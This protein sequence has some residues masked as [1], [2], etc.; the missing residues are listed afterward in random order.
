M[1]T[2]ITELKL[3]L[4]QWELNFLKMNGRK[5]TKNDAAE[6]PEIRDKYAKFVNLKKDFQE[7]HRTKHNVESKENNEN[8]EKPLKPVQNDSSRKIL[9]P[10]NSQVENSSV[11]FKSPSKSS[12]TSSVWGENLLKKNFVASK[13][14]DFHDSSPT[15]EINDKATNASPEK[16]GNNW[17]DK[18]R[19]NIGLGSAKHLATN[20]KRRSRIT[21]ALNSTLGLD[22]SVV[23]TDETASDGITSDISFGSQLKIVSKSGNS[24]FNSPNTSFRNSSPFVPKPPK[25][26]LSKS[27]NMD[28]LQDEDLSD[29]KNLVQETKADSNKDTEF[30][31]ASETNFSHENEVSGT[32]E[33]FDNAN[34]ENV[35]PIKDET[36]SF[37]E[38]NFR[39]KPKK[40]NFSFSSD[41]HFPTINY[42]S[43]RLNAEKMI[44]EVKLTEKETSVSDDAELPATDKEN[45]TKGST[46]VKSQ[47][48]TRAIPQTNFVLLNMKKKCYSKRGGAGN[49]LRKQVLRQKLA[50]KGYS[51]KSGWKGR[52][53]GSSFRSGGSKWKGGGDVGY[54][55]R[56]A[57]KCFK[58][59]ETGHWASKCRGFKS[60]QKKIDPEEEQQNK[61]SLEEIIENI[62][63]L[64]SA[65]KGESNNEMLQKATVGL[66]DPVLYNDEPITDNNEVMEALLKM[67][68]Y[69]SFRPGQDVAISRI[70]RGLPTLLVLSTGSGKSLCYQLPAYLYAKQRNAI[71]LVISPLVSLMDDQVRGLPKMMKA[72]RIHSGMSKEQ[73]NKAMLEVENGNV[74]VLLVSPEAI[75]TWAGMSPKYSPLSKLPP[76]AFACV[77][78]CHCL[79]EW[80]H[81]FRP[82]YL[83]VCQVLREQLKVKCLVG[84]T[85]TATMDTCASVA[86][87]LGITDIDKGVI[88]K[89]DIPDN[90][91]LSVSRDRYKDEAL[92]Q[93]LLGGRFSKLDSVIVYCTRRDEASRIA[94][95]LRVKMQDMPALAVEEPES[96]QEE[97]VEQESNSKKRKR[98]SKPKK[99]AKRKA[100]TLDA[101]CYHAGMSASERRRI[102]NKFMNGTLRVVVATVAFG[103]GIDKQD[104]RAVIHYN[105]PMS[106]ERYVQ[107]VGRAGRDGKPAHCHLFLDADG[108]DLRELSRHSYGKTIDRY[109]IKKF[110]KKVF[111]LCDCEDEIDDMD[112]DIAE[113]KPNTCQGHF[114]AIEIDSTIED[115]D[116]KKEGLETLIC[117]LEIENLIHVNLPTETRCTMEFYGGPGQ[118]IRTAKK[119]DAVAVALKIAKT[120]E[121]ETK[122]NFNAMRVADELNMDLPSLKRLLRYLTYD[123][124]LSSV[125][126]EVGKSGV[127]VQFS[128]LSFC[129]RTK[130][131][132]TSEFLD[133]VT[134][135]LLRRIISQENKELVQLRMCFN[136]MQ[137]FSHSNVG[138]CRDFVD[139]SKSTELKSLISEYFK[140]QR[141]VK[142]TE[143]ELPQID[144][145][146]ENELRCH[147]RQF[148][149]VHA[150]D[151]EHRVTGR[152]IARIFHGIDSPRY[153]A[154]N[155][156]PARRFWRSKLQINFNLIRKIATEEIVGTVR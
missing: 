17:R 4:K 138:T 77:D 134:D 35:E 66:C 28:F 132:T 76:V 126:S 79:S 70:L 88:A 30:E 86:R 92:S 101:E 90:L 139:L 108:G 15:R 45:V 27:I 23:S 93:L 16:K 72:T 105:M 38:A 50:K 63:M 142:H 14:S 53:G 103:M 11:K 144:P 19:K 89:I 149:H 69:N 128:Q 58:C 40:T 44:D 55:D 127:E 5:P 1:K 148:L 146:D 49:F 22:D 71:T 78:E 121:D 46:K 136:T 39:E 153:P 130:Q 2:E 97:S 25:S 67:F 151:F 10:K 140:E 12:K 109:T 33:N 145:R 124:S 154:K 20:L 36:E 131:K 48:T 122:V 52:S 57:D 115:L 47:S 24:N 99:S 114:S 8:L 104:V 34:E 32:E 80:S 152:A 143:E 98:T 100:V 94:G 56:T 110:V 83:R 125:E 87:Q 133:A 7:L 123:T 106:F 60:Q 13:T 155:W 85:A 91:V 150:N 120:K 141:P 6:I 119:C 75:T 3:E 102:Q 112:S 65:L 137:K 116:V 117:Y 26:L 29:L 59:G 9:S 31:Q 107:E 41:N 129:V 73:R 147:V 82:S 113:E 18:M 54:R 62:D 96:D 81:A 111:P 64:T 61:E 51:Y 43:V 42:D 68:K 135:L 84:L 95:L 118:M 74:H 21:S 156:G 37:I